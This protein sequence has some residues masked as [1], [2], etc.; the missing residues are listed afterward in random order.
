MSTDSP[1][2]GESFVATIKVLRR[3]ARTGAS[4]EVGQSGRHAPIGKYPNYLFQKRCARGAHRTRMTIG[5]RGGIRS[6]VSG[7]RPRSG[8]S[9]GLTFADRRAAYPRPGAKI[10]LAPLRQISVLNKLRSCRYN[11]LQTNKAFRPSFESAWRSIHHAI[12]RGAPVTAIASTSLVE[13]FHPTTRDPR[14]S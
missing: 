12:L 5:G 3:K 4:R 6:S 1:C 10:A 8:Q 13:R 11:S 9:S 7:N 2:G 14:K